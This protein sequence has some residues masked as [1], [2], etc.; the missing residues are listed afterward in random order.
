EWG[1]GY[2]ERISAAV[3]AET[4][5]ILN[6]AYERAK[7]ALETNR[8]LLDRVAQTLMEIESLEGEP[9]DELLV[10]VQMV[11]ALPPDPIPYETVPNGQGAQASSQ[12]SLGGASS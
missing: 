1:V 5:G 7:V 9:L 3:D 6:F 10:T 11:P 8:A 4:Q 12:S 2:S